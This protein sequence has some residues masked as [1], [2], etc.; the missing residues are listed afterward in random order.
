MATVSLINNVVQYRYLS[1][2]F[3]V[4]VFYFYSENH[5]LSIIARYIGTYNFPTAQQHFR[6]NANTHSASFET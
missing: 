1:Y 4:E 5:L 6:H 2:Y 3:Y